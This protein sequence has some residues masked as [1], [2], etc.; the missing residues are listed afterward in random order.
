M[1]S[2]VGGASAPFGQDEESPTSLD[3]PSVVESY[4]RK[5][6]DLRRRCDALALELAFAQVELALV[7][8]RRVVLA[9]VLDEVNS[10]L[11][12]DHSASGSTSAELVVGKVPIGGPP[13][14][15]V[16]SPERRVAAATALGGTRSATVAMSGHAAPASRLAMVCRLTPEP[17]AVRRR[18]NRRSC[19]VSSRFRHDALDSRGGDVVDGGLGPG[20]RIARRPLARQTSDHGVALLRVDVTADP[21]SGRLTGTFTFAMTLGEDVSRQI[22]TYLSCLERSQS[23][24]PELTCVDR[25]G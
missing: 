3:L 23:S 13:D 19:V 16:E 18:F 11:V 6:A 21:W 10:K 24:L 17:S 2:A 14:G 8:A 1:G 22:A 12:E 9:E 25:I 4:T 7:E 15:M 20:F 5:A